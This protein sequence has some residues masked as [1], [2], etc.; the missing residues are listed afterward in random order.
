MDHWKNS[1]ATFPSSICVKSKSIACFSSQGPGLSATISWVPSRGWSNSFDKVLIRQQPLPRHVGGPYND[2]Q[3]VPLFG[4]HFIVPFSD[5]IIHCRDLGTGSF[6][7]IF[8]VRYGACLDKFSRSACETRLSSITVL[9][10]AERFRDDFSL[11]RSSQPLSPDPFQARR[12]LFNAGFI[13]FNR[14]RVRYSNSHRMICEE[15]K[16]AQSNMGQLA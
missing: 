14:S 16:G 7:G 10:K 12:C 15:N 1:A 8:Q 2:M 6:I 4:S 13:F 3:F 11:L 9:R 5:G